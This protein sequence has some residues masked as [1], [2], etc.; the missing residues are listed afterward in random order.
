MTI[1]ESPVKTADKSQMLSK[2]SSVKSIRQN[3]MMK[4]SN[5]VQYKGATI[6]P[7][8]SS[9]DLLDMNNVAVEGAKIYIKLHPSASP[10]RNSSPRKNNQT[11]SPESLY[12]LHEPA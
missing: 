8:Q 10:L 11:I 3:V 12:K 2:E 1:G 6:S 5:M 9:K 4:T 7:A